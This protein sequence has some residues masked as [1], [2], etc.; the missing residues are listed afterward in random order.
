M[1]QILKTG[2]SC[3]KPRQLCILSGTSLVCFAVQKAVVTSRV[4]AAVTVL[5]RA[6]RGSRVRDYPEIFSLRKTWLPQSSAWACSLLS[7]EAFKLTGLIM[8]ELPIF[9]FVFHGLSVST[10]LSISPPRLPQHPLSDNRHLLASL[11]TVGTCWRVC[12]CLC[13]CVCVC[14]CVSRRDVWV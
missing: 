9:P 8:C 12:V 10:C 6:R 3:L 2:S 1:I 14:V 11:F 5:F 13:V 7:L 4:I